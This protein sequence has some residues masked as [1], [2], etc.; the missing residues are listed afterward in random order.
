M[1]FSF[2]YNINEHFIFYNLHLHQIAP[3]WRSNTAHL[4]PTKIIDA[5]FYTSNKNLIFKY[6]LIQTFNINSKFNVNISLDVNFISLCIICSFRDNRRFFT[7]NDIGLV[8]SFS[9]I[10]KEK[11]CI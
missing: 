3:K 1:N 4:T 5:V 2:P 11:W 9:V 10:I 8:N 7:E 6:N